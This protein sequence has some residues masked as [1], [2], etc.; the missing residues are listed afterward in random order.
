MAAFLRTPDFRIGG[1]A[2]YDPQTGHYFAEI[3]VAPAMLSAPRILTGIDNAFDGFNANVGTI[4]YDWQR[5]RSHGEMTARC[6]RIRFLRGSLYQGVV[7]NT[8]VAG[9]TLAAD[10][11]VS[12]STS[13]GSVPFGDHH[14][15]RYNVRLQLAGPASQTDLF[16]GYQAKFFGWPNLYTPFGSDETEN[17]ET[18]LVALN[19]RANWGA[20]DWLEAGVFWRRNKDDYAFN[21][22]APLG[23]VHPYQHTT[24]TS[25]ATFSGHDDL[26]ALMLGFNAE[27]LA[28]DLKST[29][30]IYGRFHTR[31]YAKIGSHCLR[32]P[33]RSTPAAASSSGLAPPTMTP[34]VMA[35]PFR[36]LVEIAL[37]DA[38][39]GGDSHRLFFSYA[40]S[41]QVPTYTALNSSPTAGLFRGNPNLGRSRSHDLELG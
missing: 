7:S 18:V 1:S 36:P 23:P 4:A 38:P 24:W 8:S 29:S 19:H 14:F 5:I 35:P 11:E 15:Q 34:I 13:D 40:Q 31:T 10:A 32:R 16:Y 39:P 41:T 26:G 21:R 30:L 6:R 17:L 2:L 33:G 28:D 25:G 20:G 3:P 12:R 9:G 27:V 37:A 22:F